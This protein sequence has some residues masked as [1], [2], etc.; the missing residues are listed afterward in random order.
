MMNNR[1]RF[2]TYQVLPHRERHPAPISTLAEKL[3][4]I[5]ALLIMIGVAFAAS[6]NRWSLIMF[7]TMCALAI[8]ICCMAF[9]HCLREDREARRK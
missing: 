2:P 8:L 7:G 9:A 6:L 5:P 1:N 3:A 4:I